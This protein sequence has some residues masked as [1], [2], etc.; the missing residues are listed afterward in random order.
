[1]DGKVVMAEIGDEVR[2]TYGQVQNTGFRENSNDDL[3][4][5]RCAAVFVVFQSL[6]DSPYQET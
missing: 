2:D 5:P 4:L 1:V 3:E 6:P